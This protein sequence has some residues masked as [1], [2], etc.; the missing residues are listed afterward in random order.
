MHKRNQSHLEFILRLQ[1]QVKKETYPFDKNSLGHNSCYWLATN[2]NFWMPRIKMNRQ[3]RFVNF[4]NNRL[5]TFPIR[6]QLPIV[7][8]HYAYQLCT[9]SSVFCH[10]FKN[11]TAFVYSSNN[12]SFAWIISLK[13]QIADKLLLAHEY[14]SAKWTANFTR[15]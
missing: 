3:T 1:R 10:Y 2:G 9:F 12:E 14:S 6:F 5:S 4:N 11:P 8:Q 13:M 15:Q 7:H